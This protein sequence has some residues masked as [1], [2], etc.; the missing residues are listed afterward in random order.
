MTRGARPAPWH[1]GLAVAAGFVGLCAG[2]GSAAAHAS[3]RGIVLLLP[4]SAAIVAGTLAV[5]VTVAIVG[6]LPARWSRFYAGAAVTLLPLP[7]RAPVLPS[8]ASFAL[9]LVL[10]GA[11]WFGTADPLANPLPLAVWTLWWVILPML[12][13][14]VGDLWCVLNPFV[15][16]YRVLDRLSLGGLARAARPCPE[17]MAESVALG[18]FACFAWFEL[19]SPAPSDPETLASVVAVYAIV[20][21]AL[22]VTFGEGWLRSGDPFGFLFGLFAGLAPLGLRHRQGGSAQLALVPPGSGLLRHAPLSMPGTVLVLATLAALTFDGLS[23]TFAFLGHFGVNPLEYPGRTALMRLD[24]MGLIGMAALIAAA[25]FGA[26]A[27]TRAAGGRVRTPAGTAALALVPIALAFHI[28]HHLPS[29]LVDGQYLALAAGDPFFLGW[30]LFGLD[31]DL[32]TT[33]FLHQRRSVILLWSAQ[34]GAI[35]AGHMIAVWLAH[36]RL[37]RDGSSPEAARIAERPLAV[38]MILYTA[39][40]L[41]LLSTPT[42]G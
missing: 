33:S 31:E 22:M 7:T 3:E 17:P 16:L 39:L 11:G 21:F 36:A 32:V 1:P 23:R 40:G 27:L 4:T 38:L 20:T 18:L 28:A 29:L 12:T 8:L 19:V 30:N 15:G 41:W 35:V 9:L 25:F 37:L 10:L 14:L 6:I 2:T 5:A 13:A 26:L 24:T 42:A 34:I